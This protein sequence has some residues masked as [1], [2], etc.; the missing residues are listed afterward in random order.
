MAVLLAVLA[1][2]VLNA[3]ES[4]SMLV[5]ENGGLKHLYRVVFREFDEKNNFAR[6]VVEVQSEDGD[7]PELRLPFA[8]ELKPS[9][10]KGTELLEIR[11][12]SLLHFF[13]PGDKK[14]PYPL[15]T[16]K[17]TGRKAGK[18]VLQAKMW[19]FDAEKNVWALEEMTFEQARD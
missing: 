2:P 13:P 14:E 6:G 7:E 17:L 12:T 4:S 10:T 16:W 18:A 11:S 9:Q 19:A 5:L 3:Q 15:V 1:Q 8:A